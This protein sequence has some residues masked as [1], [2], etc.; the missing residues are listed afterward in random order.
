[1][2]QSFADLDHLIRTEV[3]MPPTSTS[4]PAVSPALQVM[5]PSQEAPIQSLSQKVKVR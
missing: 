1:M 4:I 5:A 3:G 2:A